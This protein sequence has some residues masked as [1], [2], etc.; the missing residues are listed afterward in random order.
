MCCLGLIERCKRER[1]ISLADDAQRDLVLS[2]M[3]HAVTLVLSYS[4][5]LFAFVILFVVIYMI[6]ACLH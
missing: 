5:Q 3:L 2:L 1:E 6:V 4:L